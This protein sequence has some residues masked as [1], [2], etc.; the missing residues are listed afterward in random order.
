MVWRR[1]SDTGLKQVQGHSLAGDPPSPAVEQA[2][3]VKP[4][5]F[6]DCLRKLRAVPLVQQRPLA[7]PGLRC[8]CSKPQRPW[9]DWM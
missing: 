4:V 5:M 8:F 7:A 3:Q 2:E 9:C 1:Q 6:E